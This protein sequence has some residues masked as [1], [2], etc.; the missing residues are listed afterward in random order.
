MNTPI[1]KLHRASSS[2]ALRKAKA[3]CTEAYRQLAELQ[4]MEVTSVLAA[5]IVHDL[6]NNLMIMSAYA[7]ELQH[8][9]DSV[10]ASEAVDTGDGIMAACS[11]AEDLVKQL[12]VATR[13]PQPE[14]PAE[15][16][17]LAGIALDAEKLIRRLMSS[18]VTVTIDAGSPCYVRC[19]ALKM[20][21]VIFNLCINADHAMAGAP[22]ALLVRTKSEGGSVVLSVED[23]GCGIPHVDQGHV[24]EA[25]FTTRAGEGGTGLGLA[26]AKLIV[27]QAGGRIQL[28]SEVGQGTTMSITLPAVASLTPS[29][30]HLAV[31]V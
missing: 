18:N 11:S 27:E 13:P 10:E 4:R 9:Q 7:D 14:A 28:Y 15:I 8:A 20:Q 6:N 1:R 3:K 30:I 5:C 21:Q 2:Q 23:T 26:S 16:V 19:D 25:F 29:G 31:K 22:G 24:F 17:D 12:L